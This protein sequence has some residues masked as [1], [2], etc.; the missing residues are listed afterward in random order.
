MGFLGASW[1]V[2]EPFLGRLGGLLGRHLVHL[3]GLLGDLGAILGVSWTVLGRRKVDKAQK[4]KT[5]DNLKKINVFGL[6]GP[7]R[8][9]SW[10]PLGPSW[11]PL[12][13]VWGHLEASLGRLGGFLGELGGHLGPSWANLEAIL[14]VLEV[15]LGHL[16]AIWSR[17]DLW[18]HLWASL[19]GG[20]RHEP[21]P[22]GF[23]LRTKNK[24]VGS[25]TPGTPVASQQG[26]ADDGKRA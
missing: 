18:S 14:A 2:L 8:R 23:F 5:V 7:S 9:T 1:V 11:R 10:R 25:S 3:G 15:I 4:P 12:G 6:F 17:N 24:A 20:R 22:Q 13:G 16:G 26:A 19:P 21:K